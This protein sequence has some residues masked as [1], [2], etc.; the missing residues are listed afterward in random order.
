V[1][2]GAVCAIW[3]ERGGK[4]TV[5]DLLVRFQD[6]D[7]GVVRLD[8]HDLRHLRLS[9]LRREVIL[10]DQTSYLFHGSEFENIRYG[11]PEASRQEAMSAARGGDS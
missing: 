8:G 1:R 9:D 2:P 11:K 4:S 5:A 6:P 10:V 7:C 3:P